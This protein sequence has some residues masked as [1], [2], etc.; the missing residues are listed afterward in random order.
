[1][2]HVPGMFRS[3]RYPTEEAIENAGLLVKATSVP[4]G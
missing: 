3:E 2:C 1:M 4:L